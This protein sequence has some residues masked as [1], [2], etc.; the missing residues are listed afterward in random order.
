MH[1]IVIAL[2]SV[3]DHGALLRAGRGLVALGPLRQCLGRRRLLGCQRLPRRLGVRRRGL[4]ERQQRV[5][6]D[7]VPHARRRHR[8][9]LLRRHDGGALHGVGPDELQQPV[10]RHR[11]PH[12]RTGHERHERV[13]WLGLSRDRIGHHGDDQRVRSERDA[14]LRL[15][16]DALVVRHDRLPCL[17]RVLPAPAGD[18]LPVPSPDDRELLR[19]LLRQLRRLVH[20]GCRRGRGH[21]WDGRRRDDR[22]GQHRG[23]HLERVQRGRRRRQRHDGCGHHRPRT[24]PV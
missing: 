20:R 23:G 16:H 18:V 3:A 24:P 12:L 5:R 15:R 14:L 2:V 1:V 7:R 13:R 9:H 17:R 6:G 11:H 4:L 21:A 22:L 8:G 10:R 19:V